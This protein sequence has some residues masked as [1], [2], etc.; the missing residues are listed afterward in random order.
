V[1]TRPLR[2]ELITLDELTSAAHRQGF[3]GLEDVETA[4]LEPSGTLSFFGKQAHPDIARQ[5]QLLSRFDR[6]EQE[7]AAMHKTLR[8]HHE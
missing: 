1:L 4:V 3:G 2:H 6:I 5:Q 7:L 8:G